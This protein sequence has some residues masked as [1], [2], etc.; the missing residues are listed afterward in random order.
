VAHFLKSGLDDVEEDGVDVLVLGVEPL[1]LV[2]CEELPAVLALVDDEPLP[3]DLSSLRFSSPRR[4]SSRREPRLRQSREPRSPNRRSR[5]RLLLSDRELPL[6]DC[7]KALG[8]LPG[9]PSIAHQ[10]NQANAV[11]NSRCKRGF[12]SI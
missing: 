9:K 2:D 10:P 8:V 1:E 11:S 5:S 3:D 7:A 4:S 6:G 12:I